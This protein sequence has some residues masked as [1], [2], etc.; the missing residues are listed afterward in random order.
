MPCVGRETASLRCPP[1]RRSLSHFRNRVGLKGLRFD[2]FSST[3]RNGVR[4]GMS[5][6]FL[7][8]CRVMLIQSPSYPDHG[9]DIRS[10]NHDLK[11]LAEIGS[12]AVI[13]GDYRPARLLA[14]PFQTLEGRGWIPQLTQEER[15]KGQA[16][17]RRD[18]LLAPTPAS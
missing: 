9:R 17:F 14:N 1:P 3:V 7:V 13:T 5:T 2:V 4:T 15:Q 18:L 16:S 6:C 8:F 10:L 12:N 11:L